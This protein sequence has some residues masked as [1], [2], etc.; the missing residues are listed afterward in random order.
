MGFF[1]GIADVFKGVTGAIGD[2][3]SPVTDLI[4]GASPLISG[5]SSYIGQQGANEMNRQIANDQMTFQRDM[6]NTSY[7]R[8][9]K[10]LMNA[11][12]NP[13]LAYSQGGASSPGG[14]SA[15]MEDAATPA[16]NSA[17]AAKNYKLAEA[18]NKAE[19]DNMEETNTNI[20]SQ[21]ALNVATAAKAQADANLSTATAAKVVAGQP[22][23]E[24]WG[25]VFKSIRSYT[26][27]ASSAATNKPGGMWDKMKDF[28]KKLYPP[29]P[30]TGSYHIGK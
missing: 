13:M 4:A 23:Q 6:S 20:K 2:I 11:G 19:I 14:A 15:R 7:Q 26:N 9:T 5:A 10:D 1:S 25:D 28:L 8:A 22:E 17:L 21:T 27:P 29:D 24:M 16:I 30:K 18:R 3:F 12:L